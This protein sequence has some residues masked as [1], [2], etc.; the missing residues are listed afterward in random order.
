VAPSA[1]NISYPSQMRQVTVAQPL[2]LKITDSLEKNSSRYGSI[3]EIGG[4]G[5]T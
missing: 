1:S 5:L 3:M 4:D 2:K